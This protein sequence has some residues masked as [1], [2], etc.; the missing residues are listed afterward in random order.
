MSPQFGISKGEQRTQCLKLALKIKEGK[1]TLRPEF[2]GM[3][4]DYLLLFRMS[5]GSLFSTCHSIFS[6]FSPNCIVVVFFS[7]IPNINNILFICI[8]ILAFSSAVYTYISFYF[9]DSY[10]NYQLVLSEILEPGIF[11]YILYNTWDTFQFYICL[12]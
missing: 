4:L 11:S 1:I 5:Q 12:A 10:V 3:K 8:L 6:D 9:V 7:L 2:R